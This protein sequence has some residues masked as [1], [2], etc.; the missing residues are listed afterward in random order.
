[1]G[2]KS[3]LQRVNL[4]LVPIV[5]VVMGLSFALSSRVVVNMSFVCMPKMFR[6]CWIEVCLLVLCYVIIAMKCYLA[7][8]TDFP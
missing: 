2:A 1:M 8:F 7:M 4:I 6:T 5:L 3:S